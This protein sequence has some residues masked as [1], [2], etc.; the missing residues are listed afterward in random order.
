MAVCAVLGAWRCRALPLPLVAVLAIG[1]VAARR[2]VPLCLAAALLASS[3]GARAVAGLA[4]P[5]PGPFAGTV[6]LVSDPEEAL[7]AVRVDVRGGGRRYEAWARGRVAGS[8][9]GRLAGERVALVGRVESSGDA[10]ALARRHVVARLAVERVD[11]WSPGDPLSRAANALRR[12]LSAGTSALPQ[13]T[14]TLFSGIVLGDVRGAPVETADDFRGAGLSHLLVVSGQ[15]VAFV[16][17]VAAPLLRRLGPHPRLAASLVLLGFF[18]LLTRFEPSVL[19]ATAMAALAVTASVRGRPVSGVRVLALAVAALVLI[20]PFLVRALGFWL[21]V[22]ASGGIVVAARPIAAALPGPRWLATPAGVTIA[23]QAGV[24]P[25]LLPVFGGLPVVALP[26]NLL[27]EPVAGLVM[28]WGLVAGLLAGIVGNPVAHVVHLPTAI[29]LWWVASVARVAAGLRLGT[30]TPLPAAVLGGAGLVAVVASRH[31]RRAL[32]A[33]AITVA[34]LVLTGV[35]FVARPEPAG[36]VDLARGAT[37]WRGGARGGGRILVLDADADAASVL[38]GL[39]REGA[40]R[41]ELVV[42]R[43][44]GSRAGDL[45]TL[46][47]HRVPIGEVWAPSGH[48]VPGAVVPGPGERGVVGGLEIAVRS[49]RP[50]LEVTVGV[51]SEGALVASPRDPGARA[52]PLRHHPPSARHGHPQS[53][54]RLVL[55]PGRVLRLRR[56]PAQGRATRDRWGRL[57]RRRRGEGG[58]R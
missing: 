38:A 57:P 28:G 24:A 17:A 16:L 51:R 7:G 27:A 23:A 49:T 5:G 48:Q 14:A 4:P 32:S 36:S 47:G 13:G 50:R 18:A 29:G 3:L 26:A 54:P 11:G 19:R 33:V 31:G 39:R 56:L 22:A 2:P 9:R 25:L 21:S 55:R 20:D 44:G 43:S 34:V 42:A 1:A 52:P 53:H 45:V 10:P 30:I 6:T 58:P 46:L 35:A 41:V 8:L 37:L 40:G 12:T 15:N